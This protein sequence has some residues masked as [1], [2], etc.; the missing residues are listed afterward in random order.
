MLKA[1]EKVFNVAMLFYMT[2]AVFPSIVGFAASR[3]VPAEAGLQVAFYTA[4]ACFIALRWR[5]FL[6]GAWN[7]KWIVALAV[8]MVASSAWSQEPTL[9]LKSSLLFLAATLY[10][11]YFGS[12]YTVQD[13]L[14]LVGWACVLMILS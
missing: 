9:T 2:G 6:R 5:M 10:G 11:V 4:T 7:A 13:Q 3:S 12:R 14:R 1:I 8:V